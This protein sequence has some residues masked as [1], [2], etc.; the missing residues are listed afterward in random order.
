VAAVEERRPRRR[1]RRV[2][3]AFLIVIIVMAG[4][5]AAADRIA[6]ATAER[7]I[8]KQAAQEM[9]TRKITSAKPPTAKIDGFPFLTQVARGRYQ[10]VSINVDQPKIQ[11]VNLDHLRIVATGVRAPTDAVLSGKGQVTADKVTGIATMGW[12]GVKSLLDLAG[13]GNLDPKQVQLTVKNNVVE[14]RLP[15]VLANQR[16]T[17]VGTGTVTV[18]RGVVR[19]QVDKVGLDNAQIPAPLQG[20][21]AAFKQKL[22]VTI[23]VPQMP[24]N[25][26]ITTVQPTDT[27]LLLN[28]AADGVVLAQ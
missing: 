4:L 10:K 5:L 3:I 15:V 13:L 22:S 6:A 23:Q 26:T 28:A 21:V 24:Y 27:G 25:L 11:Q 18:A 9:S 2:G 12:D 20:L 19:L 1:G 8:A 17:L 14:I 7:E 16:F